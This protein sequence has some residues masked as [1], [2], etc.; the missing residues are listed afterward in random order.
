[1]KNVLFGW[2]LSLLSTT[3]LAAPQ[4][5]GARNMAMG[6]VGVA[7]SHHSAAG[8]TN[9]A[10]LS[11]FA[12]TDDI[13]L[14]APFFEGV[15]ADGDQLLDG[16]ERFQN[17]LTEIQTLLEM[18]DPA[19]ILEADALRPVLAQDLLSLDGRALDGG[20]STG[21]SVSL[22]SD[23]FALAVVVRGYVDGQAFPIIDPADVAIITDPFGTPTDLDNLGSEAVVLAAGVQEVGLTVSHKFEVRG[24]PLSVGI[25]P[26]VQRVETFNYAVSLQSFDNTAAL[27]DFTDGIY[28]QDETNVNID[29]GVAFE[30]IPF[31]TVGL[32][33][34]DLVGRK[35][36]TV[37]TGGRSFSYELGPR[38]IGGVAFRS[39]FF[40]V[41]LDADLLKK[42]RFDRADDTRAIRAGAEF[43]A[44]GWLKVRAGIS[45]D[46]E[47]TRADLFSAGV[48]LAPFRVFNLDL[49]GVLGEDSAGGGLQISITI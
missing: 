7:S 35:I 6:G 41:A 16:V 49:V 11:H 23:G 19:S 30:P 28:R 18:G 21:L 5:S 22:P 44:F 24:R 48:G 34:Q 29:L 8:F 15:V 37:V 9:P 33:A 36:D 25:T 3:A 20:L 43:D 38:L 39:A 40:T 1:M 32:A 12:S 42:A 14:V 13:S 47:D 26:K 4:G 31:L 46:L 45:H 27:D 10:L 2:A 17:T